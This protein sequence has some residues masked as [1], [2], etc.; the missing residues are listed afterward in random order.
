METLAG[1][2]AR[3]LDSSVHLGSLAHTGERTRDGWRVVTGGTAAREWRCQ[4]LAVAAEPAV[5]ARILASI[6]GI[7]EELSAIRRVPVAVVHLGV[8]AGVLAGRE[9]FGFLAHPN[10]G[11]RILGAVFDSVLFPGRAPQGCHLVRVLA[12]GATNPGLVDSDDDTLVD[13]AATDLGTALGRPVSPVFARVVRHVPGIPQYEIGH[14][15][16]MRRVDGCL[17]A[18]GAVSLV[19]WAYRGIGVN[20]VVG[21]ATHRARAAM[22]PTG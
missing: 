13:L 14:A 6:P 22:A 1:R 15:A 10:G 3:Y 5:A 2:A 12:G 4:H 18:A 11:L 21:D 20:G 8:D 16:R 17:A 7:A 9:G 19:G